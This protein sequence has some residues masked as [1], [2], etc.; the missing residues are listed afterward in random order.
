MPLYKYK[1]EDGTTF[2]ERQKISDDPL[3]ECPITGQEVE[4]VIEGAPSVMFNGD[5]FHVNDYNSN[6]PAS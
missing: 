3:E 5:G 4:R 6:N 1:R 2:T